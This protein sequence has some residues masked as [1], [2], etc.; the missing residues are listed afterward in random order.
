MFAKDSVF[1]WFMLGALS[2][3]DSQILLGCGCLLAAFATGGLIKNSKPFTPDPS[4]YTNMNIESITEAEGEYFG[5]NNLGRVGT[6]D[7][8]GM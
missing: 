2:F 7:G 6:D 4:G 3:I 5:F 8:S 1:C